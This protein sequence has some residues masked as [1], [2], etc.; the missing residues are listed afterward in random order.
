MPDDQKLAFQ[1]ER[2]ACIV[3]RSLAD[4]LNFKLGDRVTLVGDIFPVT[5]ELKVAGIFDDP[6]ACF[7]D[8][9]QPRI[10]A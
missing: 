9:L 3:S 7:A 2:T 6:G 1:R 4:K 10:P 5:L 8:V